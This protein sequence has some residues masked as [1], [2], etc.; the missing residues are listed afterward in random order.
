MHN[1][2]P[3]FVMFEKEIFKQTFSSL[4]YDVMLKWFIM[5]NILSILEFI[6]KKRKKMDRFFKWEKN[7]HLFW[8]SCYMLV[9]ILKEENNKHKVQKTRQY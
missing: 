7:F 1:P 4:I 8:F 5:I 2:F 9:H 6:K 3:N